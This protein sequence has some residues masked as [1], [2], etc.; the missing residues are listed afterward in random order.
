MCG[1]SV[2]CEAFDVC[3]S[4][5]LPRGLIHDPTFPVDGDLCGL[6]ADRGRHQGSGK[7]LLVWAAALA[8]CA[9]SSSTTILEVLQGAGQWPPI[10]GRRKNTDAK[11]SQT[12]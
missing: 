6:R 8:I 10:S 5:L 2:C 1:L 12:S 3:F 4:Q 11:L 9:R 7:H